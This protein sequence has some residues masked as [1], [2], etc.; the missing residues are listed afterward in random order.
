M[1]K[2]NNW[3]SIL[4]LMLISTSHSSFA[5]QKCELPEQ[6]T[7]DVSKHYVQCLDGEINKAKLVQGTWIQKRK[8]ELSKIQDE[9]GNTQ[10]LPLF[11]RSISNHDKYIDSS[12]QWRYI[13]SMPN[14]RLAA[15]NY[16]LCEIKLINQLT[17]ALKTFI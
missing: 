1:I 6:A 16:K 3:L 12:C 10:I 17:D 2:N 4:A 13:L 15:I 8:Y 11:M 9:T 14:A 5:E 7:S